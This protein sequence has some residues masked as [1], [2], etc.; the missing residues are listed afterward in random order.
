[1]IPAVETAISNAKNIQLL[2][3]SRDQLQTALD[4]DRAVSVAIGIVMDQHKINHDDAL[5]LLRQTSRSKHLK[6][7]DL[8]S[9]IVNSRESLNLR[10]SS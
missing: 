7:I 8:A 4:S 5:E 9:S 1:L 2:R 6:L 3:Q 10:I